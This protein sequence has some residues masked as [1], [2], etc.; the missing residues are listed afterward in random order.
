M[1]SKIFYG[2]REAESLTTL[3]ML[4]FGTNGLKIRFWFL[5]SKVAVCSGLKT[6]RALF[7]VVFRTRITKYSRRETFRSEGLDSMHLIGR[8]HI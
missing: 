5:P 2:S 8:L 1:H 7:M 6:L 4:R 3:K